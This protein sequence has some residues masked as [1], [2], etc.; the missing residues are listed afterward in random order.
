MENGRITA[1]GTF[2]EVRKI[3]PE[4]DKQAKLMAIEN[5]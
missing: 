4:F 3:S 1:E 2:S 5:E